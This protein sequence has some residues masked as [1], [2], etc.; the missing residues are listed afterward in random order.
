M[1]M[2][3]GNS[4]KKPQARKALL[5]PSSV[6]GLFEEVTLG[7]GPGRPLC[8]RNLSLVSLLLGVPEPPQLLPQLQACLTLSSEGLPVQSLGSSGL[9][10]KPGGDWQV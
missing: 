1:F 5:S 9:N 10:S 2:G 7:R 8:H 6:V 3:V 4:T